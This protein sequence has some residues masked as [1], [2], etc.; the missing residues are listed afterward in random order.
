VTE[1]AAGLTFSAYD[2]DGSGQLD[3]EEFIVAYN[4][5][6][7][8]F[9]RP[10]SAPPPKTDLTPN[11]T[12][13]KYFV[14][15]K[16]GGRYATVKSREGE[17]EMMGSIVCDLFDD[18]S[19][20]YSYECSHDDMP[21]GEDV[22]GYF[23][24]GLFGSSAEGA[25]TKLHDIQEKLKTAGI[26]SVAALRSKSKRDLD[27][28]GLPIGPRAKISGS[29]DNWRPPKYN[30]DSFV[31]RGRWQAK[32]CGP[33]VQVRF[34][35]YEEELAA[36]ENVCVPSDADFTLDASFVP[37]GACRAMNGNMPSPAGL[38]RAFLTFTTDPR[39]E[40]EVGWVRCKKE[41]ISNLCG[42]KLLQLTSDAEW[43]IKEYQQQTEELLESGGCYVDHHQVGRARDK[44][45][46]LKSTIDQCLAVFEDYYGSI[47]RT[48][49]K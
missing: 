44:F 35:G 8:D 15:S 10:R 11:L 33:V 43:L 16:G 13:G 5:V 22:L 31:L 26:K 14:G 17:K 49:A 3:I 39:E 47:E 40:E 1:E 37:S 19:F 23:L 36:Y 28:I 45:T 18:G 25:N 34:I 20:V 24:D 42:S 41:T 4:M 6:R 48:V 30:D 32:D 46:H 9:S 27:A 12:K 38:R 2:T 29:I 21:D 7:Q